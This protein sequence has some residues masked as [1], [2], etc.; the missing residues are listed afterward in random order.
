MNTVEVVI[1]HFNED[2]N[3]TEEINNVFPITIYHKGSSPLFDGVIQL[4]NV[5]REA[6][7]FL[8]HI[9][10]HY[11]SLADVTLFLQGNPLDHIKTDS[12]SEFIWSLVNSAQ[13]YG[14]STN[15][16]CATHKE[17]TF[18]PINMAS[19]RQESLGQ[20]FQRVLGMDF[21]L[22]GIVWY[23]GATMAVRKDKILSRPR[24]FYEEL[25]Q[26]V[27]HHD[28]PV[29]AHFL[30]RAWYYVFNT[31]L[32]KTLHYNIHHALVNII[33]PNLKELG[34]VYTI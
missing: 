3:W 12:L 10:T 29:E 8:T 13:K 33:I 15:V 1:A 25:L 7:T 16:S 30:E 9:V 28:T 17:H 31:H 24:C 34:Y 2:L 11:D 27:S 23:V 22:E 32:D 5:G 4:P 26:D 6:H 21:P 18:Q 14:I 19:T 20:W